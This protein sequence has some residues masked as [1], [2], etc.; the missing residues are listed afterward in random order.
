MIWPNHSWEDQELIE[1][2]RAVLD[3]EYKVEIYHYDY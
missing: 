3:K 2:S 1:L